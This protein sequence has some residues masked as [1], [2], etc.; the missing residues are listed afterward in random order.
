[1]QEAA[2]VAKAEA[3]NALPSTSMGGVADVAS[4]STSSSEEGGTGATSSS[5]RGGAK[6]SKTT[7]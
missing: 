1:M 2:D 4:S 3:V 5:L 6:G 7:M